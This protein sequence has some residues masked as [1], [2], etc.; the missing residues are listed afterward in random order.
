MMTVES[1]FAISRHVD[2]P[3]EHLFEAWI[4]EGIEFREVDPPRRLVFDLE[5]GG[6]AIVTLSDEG[7]HTVMTFE[8]SDDVERDWAARL[9]A[10]IAAAQGS[11]SGGNDD[12]MRPG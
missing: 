5:H 8:G 4:R 6:L 9:D 2:V 10:V 12:G 1:Y 3:R 7:D 11:Q